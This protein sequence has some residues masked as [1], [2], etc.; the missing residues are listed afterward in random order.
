[1]KHFPESAREGGVPLGCRRHE[2]ERAA[3]SVAV[4]EEPDPAHRVGEGDPAHPLIAVAKW[5]TDTGLEGRQHLGERTAAA[6]AYDPRA[7]GRDT[8]PGVGRRPRGVLPFTRDTGEVVP[9]G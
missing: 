7:N 1:V 6:T 2:V 8:N 4:G 3:G 5:P 9:A